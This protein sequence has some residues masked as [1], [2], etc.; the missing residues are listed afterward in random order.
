[1]KS[2]WRD[3]ISVDESKFSSLLV[4]LLVFCGIAIYSYFVDG[5]FSD[6][7]LHLI[8]LFIGAITGI[9]IAS[10]MANRNKDEEE[11]TI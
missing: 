2:W 4:M 5:D 8:G 11:P 10:V 1:M 6:N 9:N 3:G 7:L